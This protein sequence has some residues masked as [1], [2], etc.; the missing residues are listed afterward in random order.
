MREESISRSEDI[1][2]FGNFFKWVEYMNFN[3]AENKLDKQQKFRYEQ[4]QE[5]CHSVNGYMKSKYKPIFMTKT[6]SC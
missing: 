2:L 4:I 3:R 5:Q 6:E 1:F